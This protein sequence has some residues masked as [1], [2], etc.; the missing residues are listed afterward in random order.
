VTHP[1]VRNVVFDFGGVLVRWQPEELLAACSADV[2]F[3]DALRAAVFQHP[4]WLEM[5]RGTLGEEEAARRCAAR[6]S[7]TSAE[8]AEIL[9]RVREHLVPL[10]P[11]V[12]LVRALHAQGVPLYGL[13]NMSEANFASLR[14]RYPAVWGLFRGIVV[15]GEIGLVK[16]DPRIFEY[17][18]HAHRLAPHETVFIDDHAP[19]VE[20]AARLGFRT[21]L[22]TTPQACAAELER[23]GVPLPRASEIRS[24]GKAAGPDT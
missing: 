14:E 4:D 6:L 17:L 21:I 22:F 18:C 3:R 13:S 15:S 7:R 19:N 23:A 20:S 10:E 24:C 16:P 12:A 5:D 11:T 9:A 1:A 2:S 8:V